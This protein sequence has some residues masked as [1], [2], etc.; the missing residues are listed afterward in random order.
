MDFWSFPK[1]QKGYDAAFVV[2]DWLS[3]QLLLIPCY[4]TTNAKDMAELFIT[5][6]YCYYGVLDSIVSDR[7]P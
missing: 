6:V 2:V 5:H 3:K 4:K 7:G 1:D